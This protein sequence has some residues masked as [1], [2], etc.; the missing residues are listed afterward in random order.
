MQAVVRLNKIKAFFPGPST[1]ASN[2]QNKVPGISTPGNQGAIL[3]GDKA[4]LESFRQKFRRF[5]YPRESGP[6]KALNQ[7][8]DLCSQWLRPDIHTKEQIL[9]LLVFE[10]FLTILPEEIRIWVKLQHPKSSEEVVTLVEDLTETLEE[11]EAPAVQDSAV[12]QEDNSGED[13]LVAV[14]NTETCESIAF[15]DVVMSFSRREWKKLEP[16]QKELYKDVL[17]ENLKNLEFLGF[18]VSKLD[19]ISRLKWVE[20]PRLVEK[21]LSKHSRPEC[22]PPGELEESVQNR[23]VFMEELTSEKIIEECF[24]DDGC[25][26]IAEFKKRYGK[27]KEDRST[28]QSSKGPV[29][30]KETHKRNNK[31]EVVDPE[32]SPFGKK[33]KHLKAYLRKKSKKYNEGKK[34]FNFHSDLVPKSREHVAEKSQKR[35][36]AGKD[37]HC[38]LCL[39]EHQK[40]K[41]IYLGTKSRKCSNCGIAFTRSLSHCNRRSPM[42]EK[43]HKKLHQGATSEEDKG[44]N[45]G[46][47]THKCSKCGKAFCYSASP[48]KPH[49][50]HTAEKPSMCAD[51]RKTHNKKAHSGSSSL[52]SC[53]K[54]KNVDK[55]YKCKH[56]GKGFTLCT[57]VSK[58]Q[59][60]HT[61]EKPFQCKECGRPFSDSSTLAQHQRTHTGEKPYKCKDCGKSFTHSSSLAKHQR[62]HTGEKPYS[63]NECGKSFRQ[64]S[65]L[66]RHQRIHTGEKPYSCKDCDAKF[67]HFSSF[68]Y[69]QRLHKGEKPFKCDQCEKAFPTPSLLTRHLRTHTGAKPYKCKDCGKTF[70]QSSSLNEHYRSHTGEKPYECD[71]CGATF[72]RS[73]ILAEHMKIHTRTSDYECNKCDKKFKS[74]SGLIRH[75]AS[76]ATR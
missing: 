69:H 66:T 5:C 74:I 31:G 11:K 24:K 76:H 68:V 35:S 62:I 38:A 2:E 39:T 21:E 63:C 45:S 72:S 27:S 16:S 55:P 58:H 41:K 70:S 60:I 57:D 47:T 3:S 46:K 36:E 43:C 48:S 28:Q 29:T 49:R 65:C 1:V 73:T 53:R 56:C 75:R 13:K 37:Q 22:E 20:L 54:T 15:K 26:L 10:Q 34:P 7:L 61:G 9:E 6:R 67:S 4:D 23:D 25:D 44:T 32:K 40:C 64:T 59:R 71:Y 17:L 18:P 8:W 51:C 12:N 19:L 42:C 14:P 30:E 52:K 50:I 33:F